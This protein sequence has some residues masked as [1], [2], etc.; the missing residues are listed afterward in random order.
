MSCDTEL[1][2]LLSEFGHN[3]S[4]GSDSDGDETSEGTIVEKESLAAKIEEEKVS[5]TLRHR[6][7]QALMKRA[8]LIPVDVQKRETLLA[9][10]R[11]TRP[12]E[13]RE[14][15]SVKFSIYKNFIKANSYLGVSTIESN[16]GV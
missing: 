9:L 4:D 11:S 10:K 16:L 5:A 6:A 15:G 7:S 8:E 3:G 1:A 2:R 14:Q 12:K 13:K